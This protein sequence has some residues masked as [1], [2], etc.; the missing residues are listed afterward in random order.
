MKKIRTSAD[1]GSVKIL[2][3]T[4]GEINFPVFGSGDGE[5]KVYVM[6][7]KE[8][9]DYQEEQ[10]EKYGIETK[11]YVNLGFTCAKYFEIASYDCAKPPFNDCVHHLVEGN[12]LGTDFYSCLGC[13]TFFIINEWTF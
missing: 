2:L 5:V 11:R 10:L 3:G 6:S 7:N 4:D 12:S 13:Q 9:E 8:F 1:A